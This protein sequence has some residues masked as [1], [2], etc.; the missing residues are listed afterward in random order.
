MPPKVFE[1]EEVS[2]SIRPLSKRE[3]R[4]LKRREVLSQLAQKEQE[5]RER[6]LDEE[7]GEELTTE[8]SEEDQVGTS[9]NWIKR[10]STAMSVS[11]SFMFLSSSS[12]FGPRS[13]SQS[14]RSGRGRS[15][16]RLV[17]D[18]PVSS[19]SKRFISQDRLQRIETRKSF[20]SIEKRKDIQSPTDDII[21]I[22]EDVVSI[23]DLE[24]L[25]ETKIQGII[26]RRLEQRKLYHKEQHQQQTPTQSEHDLVL[27]NSGP[28]INFIPAGYRKVGFLAN[29]EPS[30]MLMRKIMYLW[31]DP[32]RATGWYTG[33]VITVS[34]LP[35][36][37]YAIKYDRYETNNIFVDGVHHVYLSF[38]GEQAY[39]R[40]WILL[41]PVDGNTVPSSPSLPQQ[42]PL[43]PQQQHD[44]V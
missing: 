1:V 32:P 12:K 20:L 8:E 6:E 16:R 15:S 11:R 41:E 23:L 27:I 3:K 19:K 28:A 30:T 38:A 9:P 14:M 24:T 39:G 34:R 17:L 36:N 29:Y 21:A 43:S 13:G 26:Q 18:E 2:D 44:I 40:K 4:R 31:D 33:Q 22:K 25:Q 35:G 42:P 37:N 5:R 10:I 7:Y